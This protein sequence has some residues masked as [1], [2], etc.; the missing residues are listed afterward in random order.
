MYYPIFLSIVIVARDNQ[1][2]LRSVLDGLGDHVR[3]LVSD[4]EIIIVDNASTD[5]SIALYEDNHV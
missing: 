5:N 2:S 3:D 4:Y 1:K